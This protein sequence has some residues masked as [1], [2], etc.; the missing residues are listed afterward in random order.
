M[1]EIEFKIIDTPRDVVEVL[2]CPLIN[3]IMN[4]VVLFEFPDTASKKL[5]KYLDAVLLKHIVKVTYKDNNTFEITGSN[6]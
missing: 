3:D 6:L 4:E 1:N 2:T 5:K